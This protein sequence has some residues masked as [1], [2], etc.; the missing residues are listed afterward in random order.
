MAAQKTE[1]KLLQAALLYANLGVF[2][3]PLKPGQKSPALTGWQA[4]STTDPGT[5]RAW[6]GNDPAYN[7]GIDC[8]KSG[9]TVIDY[10]AANGKQGL[11]IRDNWRQSHVMPDT[12]TART[13]RGGVHE[14]FRAPDGKTKTGLYPGVDVRAKG[15]LVAAPPSVFDGNAYTWEKHPVIYP[16]AEADSAV[17]TFLF[18]VPDDLRISISVQQQMR[19][20]RLPEGKAR[21]LRIRLPVQEL[22]QRMVRRTL[23]AVARLI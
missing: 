16:L 20:Q 6:W 3:F 13:P 1:N 22:I 17:Y 2:V 18:P 21:H 8:G 5:I 11:T 19:H 9:L 4:L 10:D 23:F 7:I 12:W 15:G 14:Y